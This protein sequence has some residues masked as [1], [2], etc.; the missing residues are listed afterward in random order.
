M[1]DNK[2]FKP[3][4]LKI[5]DLKGNHLASIRERDQVLS[6]EIMDHSL[7]EDFQE[8]FDQ[9]KAASIH[10]ITGKRE[11]RDGKAIHTTKRI[12]IKPGDPQFLKGL[13]DWILRK[14]IKVGGNRVR[15]LAV[16]REK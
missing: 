4:E 3:E 9:I 13:Q 14:K 12:E 5:L 10:M 6:L 7:D 8:F 15:G 16:G 11:E 2:S 1:S